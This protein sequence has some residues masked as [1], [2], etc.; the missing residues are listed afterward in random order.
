MLWAHVAADGCWG[1]LVNGCPGSDEFPGA[2]PSC[3]SPRQD[4]VGAQDSRESWDLPCCQ[5]AGNYNREPAVG[6]PASQ[7]IISRVLSAVVP[8]AAAAGFC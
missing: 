7:P 6:R 1:S 5:T 2:K 8:D 3:L 4:G